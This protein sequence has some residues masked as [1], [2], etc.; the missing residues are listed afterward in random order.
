MTTNPAHSRPD[1][2]ARL[3]RSG[4]RESTC[5]TTST[6]QPPSTQYLV[7]SPSGTLTVYEQQTQRLQPLRDVQE[8]V[9]AASE[10]HVGMGRMVER[11]PEEE[12]GQDPPAAGH[13]S[14]A[15]EVARA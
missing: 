6:P 14:A 4:G 5:P 3:T 15:S 12:H 10:L 1:S 7:D 9:C 2:R 13:R 11:R 8:P